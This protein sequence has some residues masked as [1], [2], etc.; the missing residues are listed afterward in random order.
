M[1]IITRSSTPR[2]VRMQ[3][4]VV[5]GAT[6]GIAV[7]IQR[8]LARQGCELLL[9]ARSPLRLLELQSDLLVRGAKNVLTLAADL[10]LSLI[11]I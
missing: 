1:T 10:S 9:V 11:H 2:P 3:K 7:E 8:Q 5:L 6:S 4:I